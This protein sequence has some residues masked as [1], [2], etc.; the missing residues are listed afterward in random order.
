MAGLLLGILANGRTPLGNDDRILSLAKSTQ[1]Q[2]QVAETTSHDG[3]G[4]NGGFDELLDA[5]NELTPEENA[6]L[7]ACGQEVVDALWNRLVERLSPIAGTS[8][9]GSSELDLAAASTR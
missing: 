6:V 9:V 5:V 8:G 4:P 2:L 1:K 7:Q 3:D